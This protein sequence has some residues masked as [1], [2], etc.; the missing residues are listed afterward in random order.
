M[1]AE[2]IREAEGLIDEAETLLSNVQSD[3]RL[4]LHSAGIASEDLVAV[5]SRLDRLIE[6]AEDA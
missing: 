1:S 2:Q 5:V 3:L 4:S 6:K